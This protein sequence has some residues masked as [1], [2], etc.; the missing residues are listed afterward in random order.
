MCRAERHGEVE[1]LHCKKGNLHDY[2]GKTVSW[3]CTLLQVKMAWG[4]VEMGTD[5]VLDVEG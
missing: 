2:M 4:D 1:E 5:D 3:V